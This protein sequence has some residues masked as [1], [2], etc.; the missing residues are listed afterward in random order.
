MQSSQPYQQP[1]E[2][3]LHE[4]RTERQAETLKLEQLKKRLLIMAKQAQLARA[5]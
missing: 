1:H 4:R 5:S 2:I 3:H